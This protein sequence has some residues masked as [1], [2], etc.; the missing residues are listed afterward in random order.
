MFKLPFTNISSLTCTF[1]PILMKTFTSP[2]ITFQRLDALQRFKEA[3]VDVLLAT[4]LAA[5]G[6]DIQGVKTVS[7]EA[8]EAPPYVARQANFCLQAFRHDKFKLRMPSHSEG[9]GIWL[10]V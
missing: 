7:H 4:D 9:P 3:E 10:S 5:R 6:L 2:D 1:V 8:Q